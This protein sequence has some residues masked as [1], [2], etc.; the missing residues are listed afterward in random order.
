MKVQ[1]SG[2]D[3]Y[4]HPE[5]LQEGTVICKVAQGRRVGWRR[6]AAGSGRKLQTPAKHRPGDHKVGT[7]GKNGDIVTINAGDVGRSQ[8]MDLK[9]DCINLA[10]ISTSI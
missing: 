7:R 3:G 1:D 6:D 4:I 9:D 10:A 8:V 5:G 2:V